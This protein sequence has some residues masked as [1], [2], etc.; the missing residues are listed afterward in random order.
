M[1]GPPSPPPPFA[2]LSAPTGAYGLEGG[3]RPS[4]PPAWGP[5]PASVVQF[6]EV[7]SR[8]QDLPGLPWCIAKGI[9]KGALLIFFAV[10]LPI[11]ILYTV[12][13]APDVALHHSISVAL[14]TYGGGALAVTS[15]GFTAFQTTRVYGFFRFANRAAKLTYQYILA[16]LL[17]FTLGPYAVNISG[18]TAVLGLHLNF[19]D[20]MYL[21]MIPTTI[22]LLAAFVTLYEDVT[23]PGERL[24][25]DFPISR[26]T[27][28]RREREMA[29]YLGVPPPG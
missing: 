27:R 9:A 15:A 19:A 2:P 5:L 7:W 29:A 26:R 14:L 21:F 24:P 11:E 13:G 18:V 12:F 28:K 23:H 6:P 20:V 16:T 25:W 3:M 17:I 10:L 8:S 22:A 4:T 1:S